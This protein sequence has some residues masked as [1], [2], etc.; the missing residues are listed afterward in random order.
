MPISLSDLRRRTATVDVY[1]TLNRPGDRELWGKL[2]VEYLL[3]PDY[4]L[5][6]D[7]A[8]NLVEK[9]GDPEQ[10]AQEAAKKF[11]AVVVK[12]DIEDEDGQPL[13][14]DADTVSRELPVN[15]IT[16][17]LNACAKDR[18]SLTPTKKR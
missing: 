11:V 17:I 15:I 10:L 18:N 1:R 13:A 4:S 5:M 6:D 7:A 2:N 16:D 9:G 3:N 14:I 12:T 8:Y